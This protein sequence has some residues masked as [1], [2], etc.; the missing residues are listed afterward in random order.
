M[1]YRDWILVSALLAILVG[2]MLVVAGVIAAA[3]DRRYYK[4]WRPRLVKYMVSGTLLIVWGG[5]T[6]IWL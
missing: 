1:T 5:A 4:A 2:V 3:L 6:A